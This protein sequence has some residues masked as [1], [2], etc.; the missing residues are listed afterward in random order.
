MKELQELEV[1]VNGRV[2]RDKADPNES[3]IV[4]LRRHGLTG[5]KLGCGEG[6][7]GSCTVIVQTPTTSMTLNSC[8][9]NVCSV[10][11]KHVITIEGLGNQKNMHLVQKTL[12]E[13]HGS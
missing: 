4:F 9:T 10:H 2:L 11:K 7:C 8:L 13:S 3:L 1:Y 6:G 12:Q 5:T